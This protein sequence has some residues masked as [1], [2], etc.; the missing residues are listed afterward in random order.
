VSRRPSPGWTTASGPDNREWVPTDGTG[1]TTPVSPSPARNQSTRPAG[2]LFRQPL[3]P[4]WEAPPRTVRFSTA[5]V[6]RCRSGRRGRRSG[7]SPRCRGC[8]GRPGPVDGA[9]EGFEIAAKAADELRPLGIGQRVVA[10]IL[11]SRQRAPMMPPRSSQL[12]DVAGQKFLNGCL[13]RVDA[14]LD[15]HLDRVTDRAVGRRTGGGRDGSGSVGV[16]HVPARDS[17]EKR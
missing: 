7:R 14:S 5:S 3:P 4:D 12:A 17:W 16:A 10:S 2:G 15:G 13:D 6:P 1:A 8:R 9:I 11:E